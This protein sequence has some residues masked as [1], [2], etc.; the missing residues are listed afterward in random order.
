MKLLELYSL[1]TGLEI[2]KQFLIE[3]FYP[4]PFERYITIQNSS[5]MA[6]KNYSHYGEVLSML[7]PLLKRAGIEVI[8]LGGKEDSPLK[9]CYHLQGQTSLSQSAFIL[10]NSLLH[11]GNDSWLAHRAGEIGVPLVSLYGSTSVENHAPFRFDPEKTIFLESHRCGKRPTFA[12]Q[13]GPKTIDFIAPENVAN[14]IISLLA[15]GDKIAR[16]T[17][18]VGSMFYQPLLELVPDV[19]VDPKLQISGIL[20]LRMDLN[21]NEQFMAANLQF[22]KCAISTGKEINLNLLANAKNNIASLRIEVDN[23]DPT[24]LKMAKRLG[25]PISFVAREKDAEKLAQM[26]LRMYESCVFDQYLPTSKEDFVKDAGIFLNKPLDS[27][28]NFDTLRFKTNRMLLSDN[29]VF[30]SNAHRLAGKHVPDSSHNEG[31]VIDSPE[32][33]ED[34]ANYMIFQ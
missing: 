16:K 27:A 9:D 8:Q 25:V 18:C 29:K 11:V 5:G 22:R 30:L 14:S 6:A 31:Q 4:L 32:F 26:R 13:E 15:L 24:W 1:S 17:L 23:I 34:A 3:S 12:S 33:W 2:R 19:V 28:L 21:H 20:V 7:A 10:K